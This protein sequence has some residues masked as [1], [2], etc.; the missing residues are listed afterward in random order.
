M[1]LPEANTVF[2]NLVALMSDEDATADADKVTETHKAFEA[3]KN[4]ND[5][6]FIAFAVRVNKGYFTA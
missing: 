5:D 6:A 1:T 4:R 3:E 2:N